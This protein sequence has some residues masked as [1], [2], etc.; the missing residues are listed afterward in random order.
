MTGADIAVQVE[1]S[2]E[3]SPAYEV[4]VLVSRSHTSVV[5]A[6][7]PGRHLRLRVLDRARTLRAQLDP[8]EPRVV[9]VGDRVELDVVVVVGAHQDAALGVAAVELADVDLGLEDVVLLADVVGGL[10][11][12]V[13]R[14]RR[15]AVGVDVAEHRRDLEVAVLEGDLRRVGPDDRVP[16]LRVERATVELVTGSGAVAPRSAGPARR[17]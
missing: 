4:P 1:P 17:G 16:L 11:E 5:S 15:V 9:D 6:G 7:M 8:V 14:P 12:E 3:Y 2:H 10:Q 13:A